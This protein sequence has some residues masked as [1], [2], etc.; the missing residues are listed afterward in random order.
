MVQ[1]KMAATNRSASLLA[2]Q[3][4]APDWAA[5]LFAN[6]RKRLQSDQAHKQSLQA[7]AKALEDELARQQ[8]EVTELSEAQTRK[9]ARIAALEREQANLNKEYEAATKH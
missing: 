3:G 2:R 6:A 7:E 4:K 1:E 9:Q 8:R 5:L